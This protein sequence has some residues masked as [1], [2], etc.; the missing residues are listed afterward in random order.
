MLTRPRLVQHVIETFKRAGFA[1]SDP[2]D[3]VHAS[4]DVVVRR[5]A[6]ILIIKV[7]L[8]ADSITDDSVCGMLTLARAVAGSPL[9]IS[10]R[11]GKANLEEGVMYTRINIPVISPKTLADLV[12]EGVPP[13]VYAASGGFYVKL[14]SELLRKAREGGASLGELAEI[15]GVSRR[16]VKMYEDGMG[17]KLEI[18]MKL[19][20]RLGVDLI[21]PVNVF[22]RDSGDSNIG[23]TAAKDEFAK[24]VYSKLNRIG[25]SVDVTSRCPFDAL[26]HDNRVLLFTGI[27]G[28][29][30]DLQARAKALANLS[31]TLEKHSV[32]FVDRRGERLNLEG[33]PLIAGK[34]LRKIS[35]K[36]KIIE[37]IEERE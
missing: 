6:L 10:L 36:E 20:E 17:A 12:I 3:L 11:S 5:D 22:L 1:T 33:S 26:A 34:E 31:K 25:Y 27:E 30:Q 2:K 8:N 9:I 29:K 23:A 28:R 7:A 19:E 32:I 16:A 15:G 35:S 4:F 18:A 14:D 37:I 21:M 13:L 24:Q